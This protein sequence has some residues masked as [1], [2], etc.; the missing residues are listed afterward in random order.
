[1]QFGILGRKLGMT[2]LLD[3]Q[4]YKVPVTVI[5]TGP[6][7]IVQIKSKKKDG[8]SAIQLGFLKKD[9]NVK[10]PLIGHFKKNNIP[11][12]Q[13]IHEIKLVSQQES[14]FQKGQVLKVDI[15]EA[16]DLV[17]VSGISKGKGFQGGM[18][19]WGWHGGPKTHGSMTHRR[20]GS[21]GASSDPSRVFKGQHM[22]GR[23]GNTKRTVKNLRVV[24]VDVKNNILCLKGGVPGHSNSILIIKKTKCKP[25]LYTTAK[26]KE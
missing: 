22:P 24:K 14:E 7:P 26:R 21:I 25:L 3:E 2:H 6:C 15:F 4:G 13:V 11:P 1:M 12:H 23:M 20:I 5:E 18:K 9:K 8:Y 16:G 10:I 17:D 19:R